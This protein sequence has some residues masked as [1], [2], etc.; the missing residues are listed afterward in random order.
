MKNRRNGQ[1]SWHEFMAQINEWTI[2]SDRDLSPAQWAAEMVAGLAL[3]GLF[4]L[5]C[6]VVMVM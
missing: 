4:L 5:A 6:A 3:F 2:E 1:T